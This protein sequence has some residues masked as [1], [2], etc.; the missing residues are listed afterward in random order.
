MSSRTKTVKEHSTLTNGSANLMLETTEEGELRK[1]A[2][3][4]HQLGTGFY[5]QN[6]H[7][8]PALEAAH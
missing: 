1:G 7:V 5:Y 8:D 6:S 3:L 2:S 4:K